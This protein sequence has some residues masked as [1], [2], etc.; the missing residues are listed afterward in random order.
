MPETWIWILLI[1][2]ACIHLRIDIRVRIN[3]RIR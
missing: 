3:K 1:L 2:F